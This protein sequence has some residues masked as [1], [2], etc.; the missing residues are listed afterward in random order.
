MAGEKRLPF[1]FM[2]EVPP[3]IPHFIPTAISHPD[4]DG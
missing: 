3:P 2:S 4:V 1:L